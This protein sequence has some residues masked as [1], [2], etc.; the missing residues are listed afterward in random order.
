MLLFKP[1]LTVFALLSTLT[2]ADPFV[3]RWKLNVE[4]SDLDGV[5]NVKSGSTSYEPIEAGYLYRSEIVFGDNRVARLQGPVQFDGTIDEARL[6]GRA[7]KFVYRRVDAN[8]YQLVITDEQTGITT[9]IFRYMVQGDT[10]K[11]S[12][13]SGDE[14]PMLTLV[15]DRQ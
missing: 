4:K 8:S 7:V 10:L 2:A 9:N 15:Y 11:F 12:W 14:R 6:D 5:A 1:L 13:L 3:G